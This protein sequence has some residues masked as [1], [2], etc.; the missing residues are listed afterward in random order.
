MRQPICLM[1]LVCF[2]LAPVVGR[3]NN[4]DSLIGEWYGEARHGDETAELVMVFEKT[5]HG[6]VLTREWLPNLNAYGSVVGFVTFNGDKFVV[7]KVR[8]E[9][10]QKENELIGNVPDQ[11]IVFKLIR[12]KRPLPSEPQPPALINGPKP[13]W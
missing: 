4:V 13:V 12:T 11:G 3:A 5:D 9:F 10:V 7:P 1:L 6:R 8:L 2:T